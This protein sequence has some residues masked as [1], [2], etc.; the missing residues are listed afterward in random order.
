MKTLLIQRHARSKKSDPEIK[1]KKRPLTPSGK[2]DA[3]SM[4]KQLAAAGLWPD[5]ITSSPAKRARKTAKFDMQGAEQDCDLEVEDDLYAGTPDDILEVIRGLDDG[6]QLP[7]L[8]G[9]DSQLVPLLA[10][11]TGQPQTGWPRAAVARLEF[12]ID[13]WTALELGRG[14]LLDLIKPAG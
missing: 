7:M 12:P 3:R 10:N 13:K 2:D 4:G 6:A 11:L 5:S 8:I 1:D 14:K 9:H